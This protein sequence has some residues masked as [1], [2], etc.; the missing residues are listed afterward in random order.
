ML[1]AIK[2]QFRKLDARRTHYDDRETKEIEITFDGNLEGKEIIELD[3]YGCLVKVSD[4]TYPPDVFVGGSVSY[5]EDGQEIANITIPEE[6][7]IFETED[8]CNIDNGCITIAFNDVTFLDIP[9]TQG[10]WFACDISNGIPIWYPKS[11]T[12]TIETGELKKLDAKYLPDDIIPQSNYT[13]NDSTQVDYIQNRPFYEDDPKFVELVPTTEI[14]LSSNMRHGWNIPDITSQTHWI[15]E[16]DGQEYEAYFK[17]YDAPC[18][19]ISID[20]SELYF[21]LLSIYYNKASLSGVHTIRIREYTIDIH[22]IDEKFVPS[23]IMRTSE[24]SDWARA[25]KKP[26]Y[27]ADEV[28]ALSKENPTGAGSLSIGRLETSSIGNNSQAL[29]EGVVAEGAHQFTQGKYNL[30]SDDIYTIREQHGTVTIPNSTSVTK[31]YYYGSSYTFDKTSGTFSLIATGRESWVAIPVGTYFFDTGSTSGRTLYYR[32]PDSTLVK[33][34]GDFYQYKNI[35]ALDAVFIAETGGRYAH[36]VGNGVSD[37]NRSNA[38]TLDWD[39]L[40][41]FAGGLKVGGASQDDENAVEVALKTDIPNLPTPSAADS[42]NALTVQP[43]G[44][45]GLSP[46]SGAMTVVDDGEGNLTFLNVSVSTQEV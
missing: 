9:F 16:F 22:T 33:V 12:G 14:K 13:Q 24:I 27:T 40:G 41:W 42:G 11:L 36:V 3:E 29:G 25:A 34:T 5:I 21:N 37:A 43:D 20:G 8:V 18:M 15:V 32:N 44:S 45:W 19:C 7:I 39:G 28:E 4:E 6:L 1:E 17:M 38:H 23:S 26:T 31:T 2:S 46:A 35:V 10:I 30:Y